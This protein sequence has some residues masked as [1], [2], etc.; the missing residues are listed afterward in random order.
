MGVTKTDLIALL[1]GWE[2]VTHT[3]PLAPNHCILG[4]RTLF[5]ALRKLGHESRIVPVEALFMNREAASL[6]AHGILVEDWPPSAWSVG[7]VRNAPGDGYPGHLIL[8]TTVEEGTFLLDSS[9]GQFRR[10]QKGMLI[11]PTMLVELPDPEWPTDDQIAARFDAPDFMA[12]WRWAPQLGNLHRS[13][14]DWRKGRRDHVEQ[15][16]RVVEVLRNS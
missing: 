12:S 14:P 13:A 15:V 7:A 11:P 8:T 9:T 3:E 1:T 2:T 5:E 6:M 4:T 10:D 16:L